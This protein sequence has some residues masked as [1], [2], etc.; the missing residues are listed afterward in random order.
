[1]AAGPART[2]MSIYTQQPVILKKQLKIFQLIISQDQMSS[3]H[4]FTD[5]SGWLTSTWLNRKRR[6]IGKFLL[7]NQ[8]YNGIKNQTE[9]QWKS[10]LYAYIY[11]AINHKRPQQN[12]WKFISRT[13]QKDYP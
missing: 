11:K 13:R 1:M 8:Y 5:L 4:H 6:N 12:T 7:W 3:M 2:E 10:K 9:T